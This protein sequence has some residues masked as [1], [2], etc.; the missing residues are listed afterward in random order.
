MTEL[1]KVFFGL[2]RKSRNVFVGFFA[3]TMVAV[4][5]VK[6]AGLSVADW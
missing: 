3:E 4:K 2:W 6:S 5:K 1:T